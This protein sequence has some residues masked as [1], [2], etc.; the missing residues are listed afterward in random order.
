MKCYAESYCKKNRAHCDEHCTAYVLLR[1]LYRLSRLPEKY[2]YNLPLIP[3]R[4][5]MDAFIELND[6]M[7]DI[8]NHVGAGDGLYLW[9]GTTGNG[10]TSWACKIMSYYF[11]KIIWDTGLENEGLYL[12]VPTFLEDLR[13]YYHTNDPEFEEVIEMAKYCK[14]LVMDDIGA[15]R[16]SEWVEERLL[17][18]ITYRDMQGLTTIYTSNLSPEDLVRKVGDRVGSRILGVGRVIQLT[19]VDKRGGAK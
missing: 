4:E 15:E 18:I 12:N 13:Q 7:K 1:N 11:R 10:K 8:V 5:D 6:F 14:L 17:Q 16:S 9:S 2:C 3:G 19:G